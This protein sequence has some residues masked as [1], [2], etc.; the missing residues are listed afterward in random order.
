[1]SKTTVRG[2]LMM[3]MGSA[4]KVSAGTDGR[5]LCI[6][7]TRSMAFVPRE[8]RDGDVLCFVSDHIS[9][10]VLGPKQNQ[11]YEL[12]GSCYV[13]GVDEPSSNSDWKDCI[14]EWLKTTIRTSSPFI[15]IFGQ[16]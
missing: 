16:V 8:S 15:Y 2:H 1:M 10:F 9:Q 12:V 5:A 11:C 3:S 4:R 7:E 13:H 14:L 6:T